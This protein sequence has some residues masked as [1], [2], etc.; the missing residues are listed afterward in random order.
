M[1]K[2]NYTPHFSHTDVPAIKEI[3]NVIN[4]V[5]RQFKISLSSID[6]ENFAPDVSDVFSAVS[7]KLSADAVNAIA[8]VSP[9]AYVD[10]NGDLYRI[11]GGDAT[12][13]GSGASNP[14]AMMPVGY[15]YLST[16]STNPQTMFGGSWR[17]IEDVFLLAAGSTYAAGTKGGEATHT[18]T[19]DEMPAHTH[20]QSV[21]GARSGSGSTYVSWNATN[22]TGS[23]ASSYNKTFST[24]GGKAHNNM[25]PYFAVYAWER[26]A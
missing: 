26:T 6:D 11:M 4:E 9:N 7:K 15:I 5:V 13:G 20:E 8:N 3:Q 21:V 17:R 14:L 25:P 24:G 22:L 18:L 23:S 2:L 12:S 1:S 19:V 16:V 10:D